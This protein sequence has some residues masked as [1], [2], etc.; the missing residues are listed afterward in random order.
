[1]NPLIKWACDKQIEIA[2]EE[3]IDKERRRMTNAL[4]RDAHLR[5]EIVT[6]IRGR[7]AL[8]EGW[9]PGVGIPDRELQPL[10]TIACVEI[11]NWL[12][13]PENGNGKR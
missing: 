1:M 7:E 12:A 10:I 6:A 8:S 5:D 3:G 4:L 11:A 2:R 9:S 13:N